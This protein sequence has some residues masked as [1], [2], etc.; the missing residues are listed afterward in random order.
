[1]A[2]QIDVD[3]DVYKALTL[4]RR[5]EDDT[6]NDV[7]RRLLT[8]GEEVTASKKERDELRNS[9]VN[10]LGAIL[11]NQIGSGPGAWIGN[12]FFPDGTRFRA[13][14][15]GKTYRAEIRDELW[16]DENGKVRRSPSDAAGAIS[17]TKVNGWRFWYARR[18]ADNDWHRLDELRR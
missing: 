6:Y 15:K 10:A 12:V 18:P 11:A 1:M 13:T 2:M 5:T 14:Y 9:P 8:I 16:I 17:G 3:F 4:L 7:L